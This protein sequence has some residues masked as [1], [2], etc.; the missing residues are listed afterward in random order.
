M[1]T[2]LLQSTE[3]LNKH[4]RD[5]VAVQMRNIINPANTLRKLIG[6]LNGNTQ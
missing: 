5:F 4:P 2:V 6:K 1:L 3:E